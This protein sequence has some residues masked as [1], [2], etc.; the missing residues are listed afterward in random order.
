LFT[1]RAANGTEQYFVLRAD[2]LAPMSATEFALSSVRPGQPTPADLPVPVAASAPRSTDRSLLDRLP[3]LLAAT[4]VSAAGRSVCVRQQPDGKRVTSSV[5][6]TGDPVV[7]PSTGASTGLSVPPDRGM[8]VRPVPAAGQELAGA[9][10][11]TDR[12]LRFPL[13]DSDSI[14]ALGFGDVVPVPMAGQLIAQ[15]P[16]GPALSRAASAVPQKG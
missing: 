4:P 3:D 6:L 7:G 5:V 2:G 8:V 1:D 13:T 9:Y 11:I 10:L 16:A 14:K 15:I 12:G